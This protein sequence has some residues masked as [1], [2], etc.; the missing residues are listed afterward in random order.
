MKSRMPNFPAHVSRFPVRF[1]PMIYLSRASQDG[2]RW[3]RGFCLLVAEVRRPMHWKCLCI[4]SLLLC[5]GVGCG[6]GGGSSIGSSEVQN[7]VPTLTGVTPNAATAGS[8]ALTVTASGSGFISVSVLGWNGTALATTYVSGT[9][10]TAQI[11]ASDLTSAGT[12]SV[13]V[14]N[15]APGGGTSGTLTFTINAPPNPV[16]TVSALSPSSVAAEGPAF[17]LTVTGTQFISTSQVFWNGSPVSTTYVSSTSLTAQIP[18]QNL[19]MNVAGMAFIAVQNPAPGGGTSNT[20][21]FTIT[22]PVPTITGL[23]PSSATAGG[24]AFTLT[25][26]GTQFVSTSQVLWNGSPVPITSGSTIS[27]TAQIPASDLASAGTASVAVQNPAPGGGTSGSLP[28]SITSVATNLNIL[29]L[30]GTDLVWNPSQQ[31]LYVAVPSAASVNAGTITV[32]DP[33]AGSIVGAQQLSSASSGLAISDDSQYLYAVISGGSAIQRFTLPALT[34]DIQWSLGTASTSG[35]PPNLAGDIKV[36]P[37]APHTLA[38]SLGEYGIGSV[39]VFDDGVERSAVAGSISN[40]VGNSLQWKPD[41]TEL[42]AAYTM[43][44]DSGYWS[45][46]SDDALYTMPVTANGV[47]A[48]TTYNYCFRAE[49]A[50]LHSDPATGYVYGDWGEV[51]NAANGLP[52]GNYRYSRPTGTYSPGPLSVVDP[53]LGRFYTLIEVLEPDS[54]LAFQIQSFNQTTFQLLSTIVI[55][56]AAGEPMNF[57]RWGQ[58]GLAFVTNAGFGSTGMLYV[59]DGS[60]VNPSGVQDTAA[61]TT[62]NPVPTL[63]AISPLTAMAGSGGV[64]LTVTGRDFIGQPTVY[65]NGNALP[66]TMVNST[67]LSAQ[68]PA[69]D[70]TSAG[71]ANITAS[72]TGTALPTSNSMPFSINLAP[73]AGNQIAVYS[74][75]GNDLVWDPNA[76]KIYVSMP[77]VQGDAGDAVAIV[78]PIAGTVTS[79][80]FLG[81]EPDKLSLS[82]GDQY[83]FLALDGENAIQQLLLPAFTVQSAWNLGGA[84]TF[85]GPYYALDLQAAPGDPETTAVILPFYNGIAPAVLIYDG[86]TPRPNPLQNGL[87]GYSSLQWAGTD[88]TLYA[89]DGVYAPDFLVLGVGSSGAVLSQHFNGPFYTYTGN[90]H[91]EAGIGLVYTDGGQAIQPS[92][93]TIVGS[94]GASGILVPDSTLNTMFILGQT[95]AQAGTSNYAI[96]SF[97]Q[98][99]FTAINSITIDNVV[100]APTAFIRWGSNGLAFT[101]L[102]GTPMDFRGT[103]PGQLYVISGDFVNPSGGDSHS[104]GPAKLSPV[105]RTWGFGTSSQPRSPSVVVHPNPLRQ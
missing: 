94:Y 19:A 10:L 102:I 22:D 54:T 100:G 52:V 66:T 71:Q 8:A 27:L 86:S 80:G 57:I 105:R 97:D 35:A 60:F 99:G 12:A 24:P 75:G 85:F 81:S 65:W 23:S 63:T 87:Y 37:G 82:S 51:V 89:I 1:P 46:T 88:S 79:S 28:F 32:V 84:D 43:V 98:A 18:A 53:S 45:S 50:H 69:A 101:T 67:E 61:G 42:Y 56:N 77:G 25:V 41:G 91:Y 83:L 55:P 93:G 72:N 62:L 31:V 16:P 47:G 58:A 36:Q 11:P 6:G 30:E 70:L 49:G 5:F 39:A 29:N 40:Q 73:P 74:T 78:D 14:Q 95:A 90:I 33:V 2:S 13:A 44:N 26:T 3:R 17:T 34:P 64:T 15:P 59:L 48:V 20:L 68:I 21:S 104:S 4:L 76:A 9:S 7:P 38:V 96:E 103:A 92:N